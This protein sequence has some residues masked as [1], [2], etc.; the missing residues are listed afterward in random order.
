[1]TSPVP[2]E[3]LRET[4]AFGSPASPRTS[5]GMRQDFLLSPVSFA[6]EE[7]LVDDPWAAEDPWSRSAEAAWTMPRPT[8]PGLG[9]VPDFPSEAPAAAS[10]PS[11]RSAALEAQVKLLTEELMYSRDLMERMH[12]GRATSA[13]SPAP[14]PAPPV[15][16]TCTMCGRFET[17][18]VTMGSDGNSGRGVCRGCVRMLTEQL[19]RLRP[20]LRWMRSCEAIVHWRSGFRCGFV[21]W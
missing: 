20:V 2:S 18:F 4:P 3:R 11:P 5:A 21:A 1:M 10:A 8:A 15:G 16:I 6:G 7:V 12:A 19:R 13:P 14:A 17:D 9:A